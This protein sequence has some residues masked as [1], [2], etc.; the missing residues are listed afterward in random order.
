MPQLCSY[1]HLWVSMLLLLGRKESMILVVFA[2]ISVTIFVWYYL[3]CVCAYVFD[4]LFVYVIFS[5]FVSLIVFLCLC[6]LL[7]SMIL[8]YVSTQRPTRH[9]IFSLWLLGIWKCVLVRSCV[10]SRRSTESHRL[11]GLDPP[12]DA[13]TKALLVL[14]VCRPRSL[15]TLPPALTLTLAGT[16]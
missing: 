4:Y 13:Q 9:T 2:L 1:V 8:M 15:S 10:F 12:D 16:S 3:A 7:A 6:L 5:H 14:K 11:Y